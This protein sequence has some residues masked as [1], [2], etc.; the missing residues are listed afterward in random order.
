MGT[1]T[2]A[3]G[4]FIKFNADE[5]TAVSAGEYRYDGPYRVTEV[6]IPMT[7][8]STSAN[9]FPSDTVTIPNGAR[10]AKVMLYVETAC[11]SGGAATFDLGLIDQDRS[12]A[13]DDDGFIAALAL[14]EIDTAGSVITFVPADSTPASEAGT[15]ALVGTTLTNTG[16]IVA[17]AN[18][19]VFTA[20]RLIAQVYWYKP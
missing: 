14:T 16:L 8:L 2:N 15:G 11:T 13:F 17:S 20:G 1:W 10:I 12:T 9:Y 3:D 7:S 4:L 19:A 5:V 6:E 18:T